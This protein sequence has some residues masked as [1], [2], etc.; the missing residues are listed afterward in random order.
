MQINIGQLIVILA[1]CSCAWYANLKLNPVPLMRNIVDVI[2][3]VV[4]VLLV[5]AACG[6]PVTPVRIG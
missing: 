1:L 5:L 4:G 6:L 3:V 2:I